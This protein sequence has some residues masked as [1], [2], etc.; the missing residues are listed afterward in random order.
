MKS[1]PP[2]GLKE[3]RSDPV[4][5]WLL[6]ID[7]VC[8]NCFNMSADEVLQMDLNNETNLVRAAGWRLWYLWGFKVSQLDSTFVCLCSGPTQGGVLFPTSTRRSHERCVHHEGGTRTSAELLKNIRFMN[9]RLG[10]IAEKEKNRAKI[11]QKLANS[12]KGVAE[13]STGIGRS[14]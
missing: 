10:F 12:R 13:S 8:R 14:S 1:E 5:Y 9:T 7:F 4:L 6:V 2:F 11:G 3:P